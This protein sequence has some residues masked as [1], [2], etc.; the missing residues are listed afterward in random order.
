MNLAAD[1]LTLLEIQLVINL[2]RVEVVGFERVP[3]T[4]RYGLADAPRSMAEFPRVRRLVE[5]APDC[6]R[7][8][9]NCCGQG[10]ER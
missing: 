1:L 6:G 2:Q 4:F 8:L 3:T 5:Q 9:I 7:P 10:I